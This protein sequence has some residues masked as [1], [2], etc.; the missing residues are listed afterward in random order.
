MAV[1]GISGGL[2]WQAADFDL[3]GVDGR[4]W[5]LSDV[6]GERGTLVMFICNHCPYVKGAIDRIV[7]DAREMEGFGVRSVAI[8]PNDTSAYPEDDMPRMVEFAAAHRLPFPY[9]I[10]ETQLVARAYSAI[11][12]PDF[13]GFNREMRLCYRGRLDAGG[14]VALPNAR[15]DLVEAM[16]QVAETGQGPGEQIPGVGCSVKWRV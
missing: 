10:D 13:F 16:R 4:R 15:R 3:P 9:L 12:T 11:C 6:R 5:N 14:R 2:G 8:M 7:I 1:A